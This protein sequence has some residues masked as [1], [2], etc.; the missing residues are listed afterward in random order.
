MERNRWRHQAIRLSAEESPV[1]RGSR[2]GPRIVPLA[3]GRRVI[4]SGPLEQYSRN[5]NS[6]AA[7]DLVPID[8]GEVCAQVKRKRRC[9]RISNS[10][11]TPLPPLRI[12]RL[13]LIKLISGPVCPILMIFLAI[14]SV[15]GSCGP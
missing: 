8:G 2:E 15:R 10:L 4:A 6:S 1:S 14:S 5:A 11:S 7:E 9:N 13:E 12:N 3:N